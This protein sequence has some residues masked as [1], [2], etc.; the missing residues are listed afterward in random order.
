MENKVQY[1]FNSGI[2]FLTFALAVFF[3]V[4]AVSDEY[5][6]QMGTDRYEELVSE[7]E[8]DFAVFPSSL[9]RPSS[10]KLTK[11]ERVEVV[12]IIDKI[13]NIQISDSQVG[14]MP[15]PLTGLIPDFISLFSRFD[16]LT[17]AP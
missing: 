7:Q 6:D 1:T 11:I 2:R 14:L 4:L 8:F 17:N 15:Q 13:F 9:A 3:V 16:I 10:A 12:K 5:K